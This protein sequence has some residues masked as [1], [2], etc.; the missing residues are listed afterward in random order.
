[1]HTAIV[2]RDLEKAIAFYKEIGFT[3]GDTFNLKSIG[4]VWDTCTWVTRFW[5]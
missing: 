2:V 5:S 4:F 1:M 3:K